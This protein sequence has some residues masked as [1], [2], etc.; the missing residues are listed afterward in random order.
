MKREMEFY[1]L[2]GFYQ[3]RKYFKSKYSELNV[4]ERES[5]KMFV[6]S[7]PFMD[8]N[9]KDLIWEYLNGYEE[10]RKDL[11]KKY[12]KAKTKLEKRKKNAIYYSE[13]IE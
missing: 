2:I 1:N 3:N 8:D 10:S 6:Y 9:I 4:E 13:E 7:L 5:Y 12:H 11:T